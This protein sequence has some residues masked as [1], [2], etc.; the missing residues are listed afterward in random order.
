MWIWWRGCGLRGL[1][2][3]VMRSDI[4]LKMA[5]WGGC[6]FEEGDLR[7]L[8]DWTRI[9]IRSDIQCGW[10]ERRCKLGEWDTYF[11]WLKWLA[12]EHE[13]DRHPSKQCSN[14]MQHLL[15][16]LLHLAAK[17]KRTDIDINI[18]VDMSRLCQTAVQ[19]HTSITLYSFVYRI[20]PQQ[21]RPHRVTIHSPS[22]QAIYIL[23]ACLHSG[24]P[25]MQPKPNPTQEA[26]LLAPNS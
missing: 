24:I 6:A 1:V 26:Q 7:D 19:T 8:S 22:L 18:Y 14:M 4:H 20:S 25:S 21:C 16:G 13:S 3:D 12:G 5:G 15:Q 9:V 11:Y 10:Y 17:E 2:K 23:P